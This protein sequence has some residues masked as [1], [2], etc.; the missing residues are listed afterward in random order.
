MKF[1][2]LFSHDVVM[3]LSACK[4]SPVPQSEQKSPRG[5]KRPSEGRSTSP[6][7]SDSHMSDNDGRERKSAKT[8]ELYKCGSCNYVTDRTALLQKH[9]LQHSAEARDSTEVE[10]LSVSPMCQEE[11]FCKECKIQFSSVGTYKGHKEFYCRFRESGIQKEDEN[12]SEM[13]SPASKDSSSD[14]TLKLL[15]AQ[16]VS[17][18]SGSAFLTS[19]G[20]L[21]PALIAANPMLASPLLL[22]D[23]FLKSPDQGEISKALAKPPSLMTSPVV[24][25]EISAK[26]PIED[27]PLDLSKSK[28]AS[29][30]DKNSTRSETVLKSESD[31]SPELVS[32]GKNLNDNGETVTTPVSK[33]PL[34]IPSIHP[35]VLLGNQV[36]YVNKKPIPPLQSVSRCVECNIVFY[37][38]ENYLIHK[39][40]YCSGRRSNK[41][42]NSSDSDNPESDVKDSDSNNSTKSVQNVESTVK[43]DTESKPDVSNKEPVT[44]AEVCYKYYCIP[45]KIKFSSAGTLKAHKEFYCPHGKENENGDKDGKGERSASSSSDSSSY[46]CENCKNEFNSA[47]LLKLH[48]CMGEMAPAPLLRCLYCDYVTQTENRLSE[49]MKVHVPTKA[50]KCNLCGYRGNTARGMRM[51]GKMHV[52]NGEEFTDDNMIEFEEPPVVPIQRNGVSDKGPIDVETELIRMKNEPYKRRRSRKSFEKS[53]NMVPFL[54]QSMLTQMCAA[55]GQTFTNV[56]DFVIHLRMHEIAALEAMKNLKSLQCEHCNEYVA[57]SLTGLLMHMQTKHPEQLP[58]TSKCDLEGQSDG[59]RSRSSDSHISN[60]RSRSCSVDSSKMNLNSSHDKHSPDSPQSVTLEGK[61]QNNIEQNLKKNNIGNSTPKTCEQVTCEDKSLNNDLIGSTQSHISP[62]SE[63][64]S[65]SRVSN[66]LTNGS[67]SQISP[68]STS[69]EPIKSPQSA[70]PFLIKS[71]P[72]SPPQ[73]REV[74]KSVSPPKG[75]ISSPYSDKLSPKLMSP[76]P[77]TRY[78]LSQNNMNIKQEPSLPPKADTPKKV[79]PPISPR[80]PIISPKPT[81]PLGAHSPKLPNIPLLYTPHGLLSPFHYPAGISLIPATAIQASPS[82]PSSASEKIGRKYCKH[83]DI[84]FTYLSSFLTHKKYYCSARTS[85]EDSQS[86]TA[87][88]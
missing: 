83:C 48:I 22:Q 53:E 13:A 35:S 7:S 74:S 43:S 62:L 49:H 63:E 36:Q 10:R 68:S 56:N 51:H 85:T 19:K 28:S 30:E 76:D 14:L 8:G 61:T 2:T 55:C 75:T 78:L 17:L 37:K 42:S 6:S 66:L 45:C 5:L 82:L 32:P 27:Q 57:D 84:N 20:Q 41:D 29:D 34:N 77:K 39:E 58:G 15:Q 73:V 71:E 54:G 60:D 81:L 12:I 69:R 21:H 1:V 18:E 64:E 3:I 33:T 9:Q 31:K 50:F 87:T 67:Q 44:R 88:A 11:T 38:H 80:T 65:R 59:E 16:R 25:A 4:T 26:Q 23:L 52:E 86:P 79:S 47:R 72:L 46:H 24:S 40:H 70:P